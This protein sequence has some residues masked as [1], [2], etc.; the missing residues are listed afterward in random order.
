MIY[1]PIRVRYTVIFSHHPST[2]TPID[3]SPQSIS[4]QPTNEQANQPINQPTIQPT[5]QPH[6]RLRMIWHARGLLWGLRLYKGVSMNHQ[7]D[8]KL[9]WYPVL[10]IKSSKHIITW[11]LI[12]TKY[13]WHDV[14]EWLTTSAPEWRLGCQQMQRYVA[15]GNNIITQ[16]IFIAGK[17]KMK[18]KHKTCM[19]AWSSVR[20]VQ[21]NYDSNMVLHKN[22]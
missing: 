8:S 1:L 12:S 7:I 5:Y 11:H 16:W 15:G 20:N 4:N 9:P 6:Y 17:G 19:N 18:K 14:Q 22:S 13:T 21:Q 10:H 2:L 3:R